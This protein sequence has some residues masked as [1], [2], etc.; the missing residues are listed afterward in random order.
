MRDVSLT[1]VNIQLNSDYVLLSLDVKSLFTNIPVDL[2]CESIDRR[3]Q[4]IVPNCTIP[5]DEI[6]KCIHF[7]YNNTFF[8]FNNEYYRQIFGTPM[9]SPISPLFADIV[10]DDLEKSCL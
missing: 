1:G 9:G 8:T 5:L 7:L 6:K 2:V 3:A 4:S 10:M